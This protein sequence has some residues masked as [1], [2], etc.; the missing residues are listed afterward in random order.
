VLAEFVLGG[1]HLRHLRCMSAEYAERRDA[2]M[3]C[4]AQYLPELPCE[5]PRAGLHAL[6]PLAG[7]DDVALAQAAARHDVS[8]VPL[9]PLYVDRERRRNGLL[10]G[11]GVASP[12][13]IRLGARKLREAFVEVRGRGLA[14]R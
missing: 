3:R 11:F 10:V 6:L 7:R 9:S 1:H 13:E 5:P 14:A 12:G 2:L 8:V 4:L